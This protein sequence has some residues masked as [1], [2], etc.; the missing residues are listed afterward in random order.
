M[1]IWATGGHIGADMCNRGAYW[2]GYGQQE[3][4]LVRSWATW[5]Q[6]GT[7]LHDWRPVW[8]RHFLLE[9]RATWAP[10]PPLGRTPAVTKYHVAHPPKQHKDAPQEDRAPTRAAPR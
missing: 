1:W 4:R 3:D 2:C 5:G 9:G 10:A 8:F 6:V 7:D